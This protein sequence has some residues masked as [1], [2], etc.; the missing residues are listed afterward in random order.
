MT[1][2][3]VPLPVSALSASSEMMSDER[4][5]TASTSSHT[6]LLRCSVHGLVLR[7]TLRTPCVLSKGA[8]I[9]AAVPAAARYASKQPARISSGELP[10]SFGHSIQSVSKPRAVVSGDLHLAGMLRVVFQERL[11]ALE[12]LSRRLH[13]TFDVGHT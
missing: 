11:L 1:T 9:T 6:T 10:D 4:G 7:L 12:I 2:N 5:D 3:S 8:H 13:H